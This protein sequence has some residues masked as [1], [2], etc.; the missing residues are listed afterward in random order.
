MTVELILI[1]HAES[2]GNAGL[3]NDPDCALTAAGFEQAR[4]LARRL[5]ELD[6]SGFAGLSS[7][8]RRAR[9][10]AEVI[11]DMTGLSFTIDE[12]VREWGP[13]T[14]VDGRHYPSESGEDL[15]ERMKDFLRRHEGR[16][17]LVVSHAAPIGALTQVAWGETPNTQG[18]FWDGIGNCCL[19]WLRSTCGPGRC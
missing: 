8:Y 7:P 14:T 9:Q 12:G 13:A 6:L 2:E 18:P 1:R 4:Q 19:R 17:L 5:I 10:T 16:K 11:A 3:S 15:I